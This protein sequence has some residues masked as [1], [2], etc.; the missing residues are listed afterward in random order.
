V[1]G[2][3]R[4]T[5]QDLPCIFQEFLAGLSQCHGSCRSIE[6]LNAQ[7]AFKLPDSLRQRGL[8]YEKPLGR[9]DEIQFFSDHNKRLKLP[10][11]NAP[12]VHASPG[13]DQS[14]RTVKPMMTRYIS[15]INISVIISSLYLPV[16]AA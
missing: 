1:F 15:W 5:F 12:S 14:Y 9:P 2:K 4:H 10:D 13:L 16:V 8:R 6:Q 3:M 7:R 11:V